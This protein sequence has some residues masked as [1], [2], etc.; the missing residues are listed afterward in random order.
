MAGR[1]ETN[2]GRQNR[3]RQDHFA[4]NRRRAVVVRQGKAERD[5]AEVRLGTQLRSGN[6]YV[7]GELSASAGERIHPPAGGHYIPPAA[8]GVGRSQDGADGG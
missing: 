1:R 8:R 5:H 4:Q 7:V 2:Q 3:G 6:V